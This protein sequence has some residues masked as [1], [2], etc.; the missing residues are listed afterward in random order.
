MS[1]PAA[2]LQA[3]EQAEWSL[4]FLED[5]VGVIQAGQRPRYPAAHPRSGEVARNMLHKIAELAA[6]EHFQTL[7]SLEGPLA[8]VA[9]GGVVRYPRSG[10]PHYHTSAHELMRSLWLALSGWLGRHQGEKVPAD[11][12]EQFGI[13]P[14]SLRL[15]LAR[16]RLAFLGSCTPGQNSA[17]GEPARGRPGRPGYSKEVLRYARQLRKNHPLLKVALIRKKCREQFPDEEMPEDDRS[18]RT[19]MKRKHKKS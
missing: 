5:L 17:A 4:G 7:V 19:W 2:F 16:E 6:S 18:F 3:S 13:E 9:G 15:A 12:L 11:L 1:T 8:A 10:K 14:A